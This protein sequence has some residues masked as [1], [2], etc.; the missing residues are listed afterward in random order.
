MDWDE[1]RH[2]MVKEQIVRRGISD[3]SVI[4]A[5]MSVP[6]HLFVP[7]S[8]ISYSY[9]DCPLPIGYGQ[10]IS[11]PYIV[12][13]MT[14][15]LKPKS[16]DIILEIGTGS[17]YQSAILAKI[18]KKVYT[19][20]RISKIALEAKNR[21]SELDY[22][23]IEVIIGNGWNGLPEFGPFDGIIV[24]AAAP[25]I[26]PKLPE[27]LKLNARLVI[28]LGTCEQTLVI[29]EKTQDGFR[30]EESIPVRFVPL[31][32]ENTDKNN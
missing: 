12:A 7:E 9:D 21:L 17:G 24:T 32:E 30:R 23:N 25:K 29:M 14:E 11:Q 16:S 27:Q 19:I 20:E 28:P 2:N 8:L 18:V 6:R 1:M 31:I 10:T 3:E 22:D 13:L 5:M 4:N 26:P 15:M